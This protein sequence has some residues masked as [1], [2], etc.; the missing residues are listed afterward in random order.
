[1]N[2]EELMARFR[3]NANNMELEA[4]ETLCRIYG[5][6]NFRDAFLIAYRHIFPEN[7]FFPEERPLYQ[8]FIL[9][10]S[11]ILRNRAATLTQQAVNHLVN[12]AKQH[13]RDVCD[14]DQIRR[15]ANDFA[16]NRRNEGRSEEEIVESLNWLRRLI[17]HTNSY[18]RWVELIVTTTNDVMPA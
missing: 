8:D 6:E 13:Y 4:L 10:L 5:E 1:M 3:A 2:F 16:E 12:A 7:V 15:Y 18:E 17:Y 14:R 11:G 9:Y